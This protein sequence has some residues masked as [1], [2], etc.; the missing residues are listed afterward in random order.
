MQIAV[1]KEGFRRVHPLAAA[2]A[3]AFGGSSLCAHAVTTAKPGELQDPDHVILREDGTPL[4]TSLRAW[5]QDAV[6]NAQP[7]TASATVR[8]VTNCDDDGP[9]SLRDVILGA[10]SGDTIDLTALTCSEISLETGAIPIFNDSLTLEGPASRQLA[11]D[12][13]DIDRLFLH[14]GGGTFLLRNL[15]LRD[16]YRRATGFHVGIGGCM[17]SA[18]Y[19]WLDHSTVSG[20]YCAGEGAYGGAVY[21]YSLIVSS[22]TM[23]DNLAYGTHPDAGM[24][25]FG[26]AAFVYQ[27]DLVDS[28]IT[29][30]S[31]RH[32]FHPTRTSYD[33]GGGIISVRGGLVINST[34]DSNYTYGRGGGLATF[35][36]LL[37]SNSTISGNTAQTTG[38][39]GLF[40]R[41]PANLIARNSTITDNY[42]ETAGGM[43]FTPGTASMQSTIIAANKASSRGITDLVN[44][45]LTIHVTG[46]DNLI[47]EISPNVTLPSDTL[48]GD[49]RLLPLAFNGGPTRTHAPRPDSPVINAG[50]NIAQLDSDQRGDGYERVVGPAADIGAFEF[51]GEAPSATPSPIPLLSHWAAALLLA[52]L[53]ATGW[54]AL[55]KRSRRNL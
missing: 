25:A 11:I 37:I 1:E 20:C 10:A 27:I 41:A 40:L 16:G 30:N 24:A 7:P 38:G 19:L 32:R 39:G 45:R 33:I 18:G 9:G 26:G 2:L 50:N 51:N 8:P 22:S 29:R 55:T 23:S 31:A 44:G 6:L 3:I 5:H 46:A 49:P 47:G 42:G 35:D 15:N 52:L 4:R 36:N 14:Y 48:R 53:G 17:A 12:G 43:L 28:T 54:F 34:V 21:A 13:N